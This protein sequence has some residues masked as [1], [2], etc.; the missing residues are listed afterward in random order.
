MTVDREDNSKPLRVGY[1]SQFDPADPQVWS[2]LV[3]NIPRALERAG[4][5]VERIGPLNPPLPLATRVAAALQLRLLRTAYQPERH[6]ALL[7][8]IARDAERALADREVD[9]ILS[10]GTLP[11]A[12]LRTSIPTAIYSDCTFAGMCEFYPDYTALPTANLREGYAAD[13]C[14][15]QQAAAVIMTSRWAADSATRDYAV[16]ADKVHIVP[17]G[18]NVEPDMDEAAVQRAITDRPTD[19]CRLI[20]IGKRW[21]RKRGEL[22][23]D[24]ARRLN[25]AGLPTTITLVGVDPP[26]GWQCPDFCQLAGFIDKST[27]AGKAQF[28]EMLSAAH[29]LL[30]PSDAEAFGLVYAEAN[31]YGVPA[32][33]SRVGGVPDVIRDEE[34]GMTF[35]VHA[36]AAPYVD[37]IRTTFSDPAAYRRLAHSSRA[38]YTQRLNW[39]TTGARLRAILEAIA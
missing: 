35:D 18:A 25:A 3:Y 5:V 17:F 37:W 19:H 8:A 30:V 14:A 26:P 24:V 23:V 7:Q 10:P 12:Y 13:L 29:F 15:M 20:F 9:V 38:A 6:P 31:C 1:V 16:P 36:D 11:L 27:A 39:A 4:V 32:I 33:G 28:E 22:A 2:G 21:Q 34:N